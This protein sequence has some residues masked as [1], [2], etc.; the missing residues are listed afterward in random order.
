[1]AIKEFNMDEQIKALADEIINIKNGNGYNFGEIGNKVTEWSDTPSDEN[2]P[3]EKLVKD[4]IDNLGTSSEDSGLVDKN[5]SAMVYYVKE[6]GGSDDNDGLTKNTAFKTVEKAF[7]MIPAFY[8]ND[9]RIIVVGDYSAS[10]NVGGKFACKAGLEIT[11]GS[12]TLSPIKF[13]GGF[14]ATNFQ[15]AGLYGGN[16]IYGLRFTSC[17]F[18]GT[19]LELY[20]SSLVG[21][22]LCFFDT[23]D[24]GKN[25]LGLYST[26]AELNTVVFTCKEGNDDAIKVKNAS[27]LNLNSCSFDGG[28]FLAI[29]GETNSI[30]M[31]SGTEN[32]IVNQDV[33]VYN[34]DKTCTTNFGT[35]TIKGM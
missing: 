18:L 22:N 13:S 1:M 19:G 11:I 14:K 30:I 23:E 28:R 3:S 5:T 9:Y 20:N 32:E 7:D 8:K 27:S 12:E 4:T 15:G 24:T 34:D 25:A 6:N 29:N 10:V 26:K 35:A 17:Y 16:I 31:F 33:D 2:Y 21:L